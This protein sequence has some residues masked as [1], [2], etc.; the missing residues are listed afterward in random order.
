MLFTDFI[1][2]EIFCISSGFDNFEKFIF[3]SHSIPQFRLM[4]PC[5]FLIRGEYWA[6]RLVI[7]VGVIIV[8]VVCLGREHKGIQPVW[9][10]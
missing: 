3:V 5:D 7:G 4:F 8:I 2:G 6:R 9:I 1:L 10:D